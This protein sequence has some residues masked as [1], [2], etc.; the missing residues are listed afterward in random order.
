MSPRRQFRRL[1]VAAIVLFVG[2]VG[3]HMYLFHR[4]ETQTIFRS[5]E[6]APVVL[7][8]TV[9]E[10]KLNAVL[11]RFEDKEKARAEALTLTP[12]VLEPSK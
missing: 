7:G 6:A 12:A 2:L 1:M 9:N 11:A 4:V 5:G 10:K 8:Q 3:F